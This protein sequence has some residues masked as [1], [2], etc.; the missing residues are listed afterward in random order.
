MMGTVRARL[1][2][3]NGNLLTYATG[4]FAWIHADTNASVALDVRDQFYLGR[5]AGA[6]VEYAL[7]PRWSTKLEYLYSQ[8]NTTS[9][10]FGIGP[11]TND[12]K[13]HTVKL[14]LNYRAG[15]SDFIGGRW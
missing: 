11:S 2:Y 10:V 12:F 1:G 8:Y 15:L 7:S 5:A 6:G 4:G 14:G 3:A 9:E 13:L